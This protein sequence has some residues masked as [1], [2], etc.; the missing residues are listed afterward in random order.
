MILFFLVSAEVLLRVNQLL[1]LVDQDS[2][3]VV[4]VF[5]R[6]VGWSVLL[7]CF[8][9]FF[10]LLLLFVCVLVVWLVGWLL[11]DFTIVG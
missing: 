1:G 2:A 5:G 8:L 11:I 10:W 6:L 3:V 4:L 9:R 7:L